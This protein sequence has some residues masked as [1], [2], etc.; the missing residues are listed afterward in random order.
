MYFI[1]FSEQWE[2]GEQIGGLEAFV[3][4]FKQDN[5]FF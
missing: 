1:V 3:H 5:F 4:I 2:W